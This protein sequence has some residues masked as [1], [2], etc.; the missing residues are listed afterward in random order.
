[1]TPLSPREQRAAEALAFSL[2]DVFRVS[3][4]S[5]FGEPDEAVLAV[6][7][8][9]AAEFVRYASAAARNKRHAREY[10]RIRREVREFLCIAPDGAV[11]APV[12]AGMVAVEAARLH[13]K[14]RHRPG[15]ELLEVR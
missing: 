8:E 5:L 7:L 1:V 12:L 6:T 10:R 13:R 4:P 3:I 9:I 2:A 11:P 15:H 14:P